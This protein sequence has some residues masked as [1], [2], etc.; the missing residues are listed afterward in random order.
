[1][2]YLILTLLIGCGS[3]AE[4]VDERTKV[5]EEDTDKVVVHTIDCKREV[6]Y[7]KGE[8]GDRGDVG[9]ITVITTPNTPG[10][11]GVVGPRGVD[12]VSCYLEHKLV[13]TRYKRGKYTY[14]YDV[15]MI[16][17]DSSMYIAREVKYEDLIPTP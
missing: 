1:M 14:Y 2:I 5:P 8:K 11:D 4:Y 9:D 12:A 3:S 15:K 6:I 7:E 13:D 10:R 16:C 17:P